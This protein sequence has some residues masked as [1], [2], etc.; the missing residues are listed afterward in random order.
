MRQLLEAIGVHMVLSGDAKRNR[1]DYLEITT[2]LPFQVEVNTG[3]GILA[4]TYLDAATFHLGE[5]I[6]AENAQTEAAIQAKNDALNFIESSFSSVRSP[7]QEIER[8]FR[9]WD[10][11][12][13]SLDKGMRCGNLSASN[14]AEIRRSWLRSALWSRSK[15]PRHY[16]PLRPTSRRS[17]SRPMRG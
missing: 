14:Q 4:K 9:F 12:S 15:H 7:R 1:D 2:S 3:F 8:G 17:L 16:P 10:T 11:V 5:P 6:T 13:H